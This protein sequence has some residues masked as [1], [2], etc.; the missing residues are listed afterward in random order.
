MQEIR[1]INLKT[2]N[3]NDMIEIN[4]PTAYY[5][6]MCIRRWCASFKLDAQSQFSYIFAL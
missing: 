3:I 4:L 2:K 5:S 1:S 6:M